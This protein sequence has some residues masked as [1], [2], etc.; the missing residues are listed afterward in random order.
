M[1][2]EQLK[3][4]YS[5]EGKTALVTGG[6][7]GI[8]KE[9]A[10]LLGARGAHVAINYARNEAA[11]EEVKEKIIS[12]GGKASVIGFDVSSEEQC[13]DAFKRLLEEHQGLGLLVNNAG[14]ARDNLIMRTKGEDW[15]ATLQTN[16]SSAFFLSK[17]AIKP[18]MKARF[19]RVINIS[20]VIGE[21]GNAGQT[22]YAASKA[23]LI[24]FTKSLAKEVASRGITVNA[25]T[26]GYIQTDMTEEMDEK[27]R[28]ELQQAI[29]LGRLGEPKD[30]AEAVG[31]LA[32]GAGS[33]ITGAT[34]AVNGGLRI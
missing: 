33:Y 3:E 9:I 21:M 10:L 20:S 29:P 16:L 5:L 11:A 19:G 8:G 28:A 6:S 1:N 13:V 30:I 32:G 7:R 14:I 27:M 4:S 34:L 2:L 31:F 12:S 25:V 17:L 15:Q 22:A 26:P 24:G 18:M 23:G